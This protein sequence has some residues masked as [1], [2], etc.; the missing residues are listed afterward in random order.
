[1]ESAFMYSLGLTFI[2]GTFLGIGKWQNILFY[3]TWQNVS[4]DKQNHTCIG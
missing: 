3:G 2:L 1:M 4:F